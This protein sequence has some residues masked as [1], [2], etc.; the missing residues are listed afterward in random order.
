M[1]NGEV[2]VPFVEHYLDDGFPR[3]PEEEEAERRW[4]WLCGNMGMAAKGEIVA[5]KVA[6]LHVLFDAEDEAGYLFTEP[7]FEQPDGLINDQRYLGAFTTDQAAQ[8]LAGE[9]IRLR[10]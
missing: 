6:R 10:Y 9:D 4:I 8:W 1:T 7:N 3:S 5:H 2:I